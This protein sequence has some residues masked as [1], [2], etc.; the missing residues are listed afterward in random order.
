MSD[1]FTGFI[2]PVEFSKTQYYYL[3][4]DGTYSFY[5]PIVPIGPKQYFSYNSIDNINKSTLPITT[6]SSIFS[7]SQKI[8]Q[9]SKMKIIKRVNK[10]NIRKPPLSQCTLLSKNFDKLFNK[11]TVE[12]PKIPGN[13]KVISEKIPKKIP[14]KIPGNTKV[15]SEKI[16]KKIP[17]NTKVIS[18][19]IPGNTKVISEKIPKRK[20]VVPKKIPKRKKVVPKK[21][22]K[23][24]KVIPKKVPKKIYYETPLIRNH[25]NQVKLITTQ[26]KVSPKSNSENDK[27]V[28]I[29][30]S[31][32]NNKVAIKLQEP[33][34]K[35]SNIH[36]L[37][38][39]QQK[40][41][42]TL[43]I[44]ISTYVIAIIFIIISL[45]SAIIFI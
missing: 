13:T 21:I 15:I 17:G 9:L 30:M 31:T 8:S 1:T 36:Y 11:H 10:K 42:K 22:P 19:K 25:Q 3:L 37:N 39:S 18:E 14:K 16:P 23:H 38:E 41:T 2:E 29:N 26:K 7:K 28:D 32:K 40:Q 4:P 35:K 45:I 6:N 12:Q 33:F 24:S 5:H 44:W 34:V 43:Y 20:K 27:V